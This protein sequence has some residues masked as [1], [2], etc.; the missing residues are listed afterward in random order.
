MTV[1]A[2]ARAVPHPSDTW[3]LGSSLD[4]QRDILQ[5]FVRGWR[6][7]GDVA[8]YRTPRPMYVLAHPDHVRHI[9]DEHRDSH[10]RSGYVRRMLK[11]VA[12]E[13]LF[14]CDERL[15][16]QQ[17]G[18]VGAPLARERCTA[19]ADVMAE[20]A[21]TLTATLAARAD[22]G[23]LPVLPVLTRCAV[24]V[25]GRILF[26]TR[27]WARVADTLYDALVT[28][29]EWAIPRVTGFPTP[30]ERLTSAYRRYR[31][32]MRTRDWIIRGAIVR[33]RE[34]PTKDLISTYV[35]ARDD[36][37]GAALD[38]D[39]VLDAVTSALFGAY[40]GAPALGWALLLLAQHPDIVARLEAEVDATLAG[41]PPRQEHLAHLDYTAMVVSEALRLYPPLWLMS[42]PPVTD[43]VIGGYHIPARVYLLAVPYIT[44]RHPE[45]WSD[46]ESFDPDRFAAGADVP[47]H[48][49][50][51]L[52][53][54]KG[55]RS[56]VGETYALLQLR[57]TLAALVQRLRFEA[58][59][60]YDRGATR[61][62][63]LRPADELPLRVHL[64]A[65]VAA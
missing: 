9:L 23:V 1:A 55:H 61:T 59:P 45:F 36:V 39:R 63:L 47:R 29:W 58:L 12:G 48:P 53:F 41:G 24:D 44:H 8:W 65:P 21:S 49:Y 64:R 54:G 10:P 19:W 60:G 51:Y 14:T 7:V 35:H 31:A 18:V 6:E 43:E 52:P 56:C 25:M 28:S 22:A 11:N 38:E 15:W 46:P 34:A 16:A 20:G 26:G 27:D 17:A 50:A 57:M 33:R 32:A 4:F 5:T 2:G 13:G 62:F 42:R 40:K 3:V 30:V 37:S